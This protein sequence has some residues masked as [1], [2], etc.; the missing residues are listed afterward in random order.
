MK[1]I[2]NSLLGFFILLLGVSAY[3]QEEKK[4]V[5]ANTLSDT[6]TVKIDYELAG[7]NYFGPLIARKMY[8]LEKT[9]TYV[10]KGTPMSPSDKTIVQKPV[11]FYAI[12]KLAKYYK[13]Q[14]KKNRISK[15]EAIDKLD[16]ILNIGYVIYSQNTDEFEAYLREQKKPQDIEKAFDDVVLQ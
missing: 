16:R 4:F 10:E 15:S 7:S 11:I 14:V 6:S 1:I 5:F 9:Y 2:R 3:G 13:K 12:K 8:L